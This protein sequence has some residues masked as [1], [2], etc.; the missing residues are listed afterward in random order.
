MLLYVE[1]LAES[2]EIVIQYWYKVYVIDVYVCSIFGGVQQKCARTSNECRRKRQISGIGWR[3]ETTVLYNTSSKR[4]CW[5]KQWP[6]DLLCWQR[7]LVCEIT[8]TWKYLHSNWASKIPKQ[9]IR[10]ASLRS[11]ADL[12]EWGLMCKRCLWQWE[13]VR[14][15]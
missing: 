7:Q 13:E 15:M 5:P 9:R 14:L 3:K 6:R 12:G 11:I 2:L 8:T 10:P 1:L 4:E